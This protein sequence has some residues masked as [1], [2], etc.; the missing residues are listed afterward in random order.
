MKNEVLYM[1][2][3]FKLFSIKLL[4]SF[5]CNSLGS[6][7]LLLSLSSTNLALQNKKKFV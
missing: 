2:I 7:T 4:S 6:T 5:I 3:G 1:H